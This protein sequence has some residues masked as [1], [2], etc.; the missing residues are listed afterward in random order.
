VI[1][2]FIGLKNSSFLAGFEASNL[3]SSG[4]HATTKI[5]EGDS[6]K[7]YFKGVKKI[8]TYRN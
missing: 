2:I 6:G 8:K 1:Q 4:K 5:T 3:G 7:Y